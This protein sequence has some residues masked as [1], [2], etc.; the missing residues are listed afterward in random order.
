MILT[1][2]LR[3]VMILTALFIISLSYIANLATY[4][5]TTP[6]PA[7]TLDTQTCY[8]TTYSDSKCVEGILVNVEIAQSLQRFLIL[9]TVVAVVGGVA[10]LIDQ[11]FL[12]KSRKKRERLGI[13]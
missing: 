2:R 7:E 4:I 11:R 10:M 9:I 5:L 8:C 13:P 6:C 12:N 3:I 1:P